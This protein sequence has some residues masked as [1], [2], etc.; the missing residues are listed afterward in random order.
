M[1]D[2]HCFRH[3]VINLCDLH[4][5]E[6]DKLPF[7]FEGGSLETLMK[8]IDREG[9]FTLIPELAGFDVDEE[10]KLQIRHFSNIV[11]LREVSLVYTRRYAKTKLI[12]ALAN[13]IKQ[14]IPQNM[15]DNSRG[16]IVEWR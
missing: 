1:S 13:S 15:L 7:E 9:G 11:P 16:T 10:R 8:I 12:E 5:I 3:Q 2:G 6:T 4:D 14:A